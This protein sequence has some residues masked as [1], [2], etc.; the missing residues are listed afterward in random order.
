MDILIIIT[1]LLAL[2]IRWV[3]LGYRED[4]KKQP[5]L[6]NGLQKFADQTKMGFQSSEAFQ[7]LKALKKEQL[8]TFSIGDSLME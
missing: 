3:I 7:I 5:K 6:R 1:I 8:R 4:P 2:I